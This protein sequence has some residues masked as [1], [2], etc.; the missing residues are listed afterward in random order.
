MT[1]EPAPEHVE[2][3]LE[4]LEV[5]QGSE[6]A[7][8]ILAYMRE[9]HPEL[10]EFVMDHCLDALYTRPGLTLQQRQLV[11][12]STL[13]T[14]GDTGTNLVNH[15]EAALNLGLTE[16]ELREALLHLSLYAGM[17]RAI[18]AMEVLRDVLAD[19]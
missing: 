12:I 5:T 1:D 17:P 8:E 13:V 9:Y 14:Q 15:F 11:V 16:E 19:R 3:G 2:T 10:P 18:N 4:W 6:R 7:G